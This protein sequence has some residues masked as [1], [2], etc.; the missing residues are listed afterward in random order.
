MV[1]ISMILTISNG[2]DKY[3]LIHQTFPLH[4]LEFLERVATSDDNTVTSEET[5]K[6]AHLRS[7]TQFPILIYLC[8]IPLKDQTKVRPHY[9]NV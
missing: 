9:R 4:H 8:R 7:L 1:T 2:F 3:I 5:T 6:Q